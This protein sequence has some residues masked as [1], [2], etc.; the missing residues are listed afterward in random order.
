MEDMEIEYLE[1]H[2]E[3]KLNDIIPSENN[4]KAIS[5]TVKLI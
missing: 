1:D 5:I 2:K 3:S 4:Q